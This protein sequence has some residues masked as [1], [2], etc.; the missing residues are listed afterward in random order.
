MYENDK[1]PAFFHQI[2]RAGFLT[3]SLVLL[4][5]L[6]SCASSPEIQNRISTDD[7]IADFLEGTRP[8]QGDLLDLP[9]DYLFQ[10]G[11]YEAIPGGENGLRDILL[12]VEPSQWNLLLSNY[13]ANP[14]NERYIAGEM[15]FLDGEVSRRLT[16][17]GLR[18]RGN[19]FSRVK[20]ENARVHNSGNPDYNQAHYRLK[21]DY[22]TNQEF[23]G[24]EN[25]ILKRANGDPSYIRERLALELMRDFGVT[26]VQRSTHVRLFLLIS[27]DDS[28]S[29]HG[30][31]QLM[32]AF[33]KE[34]LK[35]RYG[36]NDDGD[37]WKC[38]WPAGL[39]EQDPSDKMGLED[40]DNGI[41]FP[42]DLKTNK[43]E[44]DRAK[45]EFTRFITRLN[46][47]SN[48]EFPAWA[49]EHIAVDTLLRAA[50]VGTL[51]GSWDDYWINQNNYYLYNDEDSRWHYIPYDLDN[52]FGTAAMVDPAEM[53]IFNPD[54][55]EPG[56]RPLFQ[57]VLNVPEYRQRYA[58]YILE[59]LDEDG[60]LLA[61]G[62]VLQRIT[63]W[64]EEISGHIA[65]DT[66]DNME[67]SDHTADWSQFEDY[68]LGFSEQ[69]DR[70]NFFR[71]RRKTALEDI[72][73]LYPE[74]IDQ[75]G[76]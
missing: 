63:P 49:E 68:S 72:S 45:A 6:S 31:Y 34:L 17:I 61:A 18:I 8:A 53:D 70:I 13:D 65:N 56:S 58:E 44:L 25:L 22:Q 4:F 1:L 23:H 29:Y 16:G 9:S 28:I 69:E 35:D 62:A 59:L 15:Y 7:L 64:M 21:M 66:G 19:T 11:D 50:A 41:S 30:V 46:T 20:P 48:A 54:A 55:V 10:T 57:R 51:I 37:L 71:Q 60:G 5:F 38:L 40:P 12:V 75:E 14:Q 26:G 73:R 2:R 67:L 42:Y 52:T 33:E 27:G 32:E 36:S 39:D 24:Q 3:L 43:D 76:E 74:L 47:L